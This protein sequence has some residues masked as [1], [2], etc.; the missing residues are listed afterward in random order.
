MGFSHN[1]FH[2]PLETFTKET[3]DHKL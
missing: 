1:E 3:P 2:W